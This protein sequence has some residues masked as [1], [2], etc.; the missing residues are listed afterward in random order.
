MRKRRPF[1]RRDISQR[2]AKPLACLQMRLH[3]IQAS[4]TPVST[5]VT[6]DSPMEM[7]GQR[8]PARIHACTDP[9]CC[10]DKGMSPTLAGGSVAIYA[11]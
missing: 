9:S 7:N 1:D 6:F 3:L 8:S 2:L 10:C 5:S 11:P 4:Q